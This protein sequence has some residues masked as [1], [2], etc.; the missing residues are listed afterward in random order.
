[1]N[2]IIDIAGDGY[3]VMC[4]DN[5]LVAI[6]D[7]EEKLKVHFSDIA[8]VVAHGN[9][10]SYTNTL[11]QKLIEYNIP[12]IICDKAH[13]PFG[14]LLPFC[15]HYEY[16][17]RIQIQIEAS[18]PAKKSAWKQIISAKLLNQARVLHLFKEYQAA[19]KLIGYSKDVRSADSD[20]REGVGARLYFSK[21]FSDFLRNPES[22]DVVNA[23]LNYGY[24]IV[25]SA[26]ARA[27]C[28]SGLNPSF[29]LFHSS[30]HN[31]HCL[32]DDLVEPLRPFVDKI[33]KAK[34][35]QIIANDSLTPKLKKM[36]SE[37]LAEKI[38]FEDHTCPVKI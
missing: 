7:S 28:G 24:A 4:R 5:S 37:V 21:L 13:N 1:M 16:G 25:R 11:L 20:N 31:P 12:F 6:K 30:G 29:G 8:C 14:M 34:Y 22:E 15:R 17:K 33:V 32:I 18:L 36:L 23:A 9:S 38:V 2:R 35:A 3:A 27:V 19:D 10:L 26:V